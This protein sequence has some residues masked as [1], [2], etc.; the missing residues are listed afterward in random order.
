MNVYERRGNPYVME[1][2]IPSFES[3]KEKR[4]GVPITFIRNFPIIS[5]HLSS[6]S[7]IFLITIMGFL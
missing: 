2:G 5:S 6:I 4:H 1:N 7:S 3:T